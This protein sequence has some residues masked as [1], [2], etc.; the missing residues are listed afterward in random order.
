MV[1]KLCLIGVFSVTCFVCST[2]LLGKIIENYWDLFDQVQ[3][4]MKTKWDNNVNNQIDTVY[5]KN[6]FELWWSIG[7]VTICEEKQTLQRRIRSYKCSLCWK[8][9]CE[10]WWPIG[11]SVDCD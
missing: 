1:W 10:L 7:P 2:E 5:T 3:S 9:Y 6:N 8:Q 4:V 11:S